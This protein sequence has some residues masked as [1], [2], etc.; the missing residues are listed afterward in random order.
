PACGPRCGVF[1]GQNACRGGQLGV[2]C[3]WLVD[4][5]RILKLLARTSCAPRTNRRRNFFTT[6]NGSRRRGN[7]KP[8]PKG[9]SP[10]PPS[11]GRP[12]ATG[13][14]TSGATRQ[15]GKSLGPRAQGRPGATGTEE[16]LR[17]PARGQPRATRQRESPGLRLGGIRSHPATGHL[18]P[19]AWGDSEPPGNGTPPASGLGRLGATRQRDTSGPRA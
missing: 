8:L 5:Q 14:R 11:K 9:E 7:P 4:G 19:P 17:H 12:L 13:K 3:G 2:N 18:G 6:G 1:G 10:K 16:T 15:P